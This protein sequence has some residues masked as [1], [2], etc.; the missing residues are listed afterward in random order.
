[1]DDMTRAALEAEFDA[2]SAELSGMMENLE[3][4]QRAYAQL[5]LALRARAV[6]EKENAA[7]EETAEMER[8]LARCQQAQ[9]DL[10]AATGAGD[11]ARMDACQAALDAENLAFDLAQRHMKDACRRYQDEL[12]RQGFASEQAYQE[13]FLTL[14]AQKKLEEQVEP[15]R[16]RYAELLRRCEELAALLENEA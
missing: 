1:M 14:P 9:S 5:A 16:A 11:R 8:M 7:R 10:R 3:E 2:K 13:A 12:R 4:I 6:K 15:F